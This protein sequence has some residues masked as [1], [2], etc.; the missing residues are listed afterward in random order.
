M[1]NESNPASQNRGSGDGA[2]RL[3]L[4]SAFAVQARMRPSFSCVGIVYEADTSGLRIWLEAWGEEHAVWQFLEPFAP[5]VG[6]RTA[7]A[8]ALASECEVA[9]LTRPVCDRRATARQSR[10]GRPV[11]CG[12]AKSGSES[13]TGDCD[14]DGSHTR[15]V[16]LPPSST[17]HLAP[18][19]HSARSLVPGG[20]R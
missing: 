17:H 1:Y 3:V 18:R 15:A 16:H 20:A 4:E 5:P 9:R 13:D 8:G 11:R 10:A 6:V 19:Q 14:A 2:A 12:G 7:R